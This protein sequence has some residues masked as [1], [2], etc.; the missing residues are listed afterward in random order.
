MKTKNPTA[1]Y[2]LAFI[3]L[4]RDIFRNSLQT[5]SRAFNHDHFENS[6]WTDFI[7]L[8]YGLMEYIITQ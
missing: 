6:K 3:C 7:R 2:H 4:L 5:H 1:G 8:V